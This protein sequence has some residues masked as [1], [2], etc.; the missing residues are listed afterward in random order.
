[1][2]ILVIHVLFEVVFYSFD[3]EVHFFVRCHFIFSGSAVASCRLHLSQTRIHSSTLL[4]VVSRL[5]S[6]WLLRHLI[7]RIIL[8]VLS[9]S[10]LGKGSTRHSRHCELIPLEGGLLIHLLEKL[11][12]LVLLDQ[13]H[14]LLVLIRILVQLEGLRS[15]WHLV[16]RNLASWNLCVIITLR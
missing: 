4:V 12:R 14:Q 6:Y 16:R 2:S 15:S 1:M 3:P 5:P 8:L 7:Y 10:C 13:L 11:Q 9:H